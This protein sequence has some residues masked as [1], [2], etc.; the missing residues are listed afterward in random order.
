MQGMPRLVVERRCGQC[1]HRELHH[2][3]NLPDVPCLHRDCECKAF[4]RP[5]RGP[6]S[7]NHRGRTLVQ[8]VRPYADT[9]RA[10]ATEEE[11]TNTFLWLAKNVPATEGTRRKWRK[12]V[13]QT[14]AALRLKALHDTTRLVTL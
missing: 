10:C 12:V 1:D 14:K 4:Q 3:S 2:S 5:W 9:L 11:L 8:M 7:G 6:G 13:E